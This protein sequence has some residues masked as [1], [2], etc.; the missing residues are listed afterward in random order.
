MPRFMRW[1]HCCAKT[2]RMPPIHQFLSVI[3]SRTGPQREYRP[4]R[5]IV[6]ETGHLLLLCFDSQGMQSCMLLAH[7]NVLALGYTRTMMGFLLLQPQPSRITVIGLGG[8]S[9]VK[10]CHRY[11][12]ASSIAAIEINPEVIAL[13]ER[14]HIPPDDERLAIIRADG[15]DYVTSAASRSDVL[16]L[17]GFDADGLPG[18]LGSST[19]YA[20]CYRH[21]TDNGVLVANFLSDDP[22]LG[23]YLS[24]LRSVFGLSVAIAP[25]EDNASNIIAFAWK[26]DAPLPSLE[27][28][29][30]QA[31]RIADQHAIDL[32]E[33]AVRIELGAPVTT[34]VGSACRLL[35]EQAQPV[36]LC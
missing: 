7:P 4:D 23:G 19:F 33:A 14:F 9:L 31:S 35:A 17:D 10:Y 13:R 32:V 34:G 20:A 16:L 12:P 15:A 27:V 2:E 36:G 22:D 25:A 26:G 3:A 24:A 18:A 28:M 8:G 29:V 21:L 1:R 5:P 6:V 11:L 30:E